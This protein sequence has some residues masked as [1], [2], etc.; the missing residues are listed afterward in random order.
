MPETTVV[1]VKDVNLA[2]PDVDHIGRRNNR[3][4]LK[5]SVWCNRFPIGEG[6]DRERAVELYESAL[7]SALRDD[8]G[9]WW[10]IETLRGKRL[11]C[12]C[13]P[14]P[15]HGDVLVKLLAER[16]T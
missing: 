16:K 3:Y 6:V 4:R 9:K 1:H 15:C 10:D 14:K 2:D 13:H 12:W 8:P 11:A 7:R 5:E